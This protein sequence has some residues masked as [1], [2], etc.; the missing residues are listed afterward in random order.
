M[1]M[2]AT[3]VV[4]S[5]L[6]FV[7][8]LA[9]AGVLG[10][11]EFGRFAV[12]S[13]A[14]I[15][16]GTLAFDWLRLSTTRFVVADQGSRDPRLHP[17]L[18]AGYGAASLLLIAGGALAAS[19]AGTI[20]VDATTVAVVV[21]AAVANGAFEYRAALA[22]ALF[23]NRA[24][25]ALILSKNLLAFGLALGAG[26]VLGSAAA[27][28]AV[29]ALSAA[30]SA[31]GSRGLV[32][33]ARETT[34]GRPS[35]GHLALFARY[36]APIVGANLLYGA[37]VL[38]NR[39]VATSLFGYAAAGQISLPTD[40]TIRLFLSVGAALDVYLFQVVVRRRATDGLAGAQRQIAGNMVR[41]AAALVL[42]AVGYVMA[43][44]AFE[45]LVV[46][47]RF[48]GEFGRIATV[49]VPGVL[50]FCLVQFALSPVF[51]IENRTAPLLV[52]A[53]AAAALDVGL[54]AAM[55]GEPSLVALAWIHT[56]SLLGGSLV[57]LWP[58]LGKAA[59]WPP[60]REILVVLAAAGL[61][62]AALWPLRAIASPWLSLAASG[63]VG[64]AVFAAVLIGFD[65]ADLRERLL[66]VL[67][68]A[69]RG[70]VG[71]PPVAAEAKP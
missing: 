52:A 32:P 31:L 49:L 66:G 18:D 23:A 5:G 19:L 40:V 2:I 59:C 46:P 47:Q 56:A 58:A 34:S 55:P 50:T 33:A 12:A 65:V 3:F 61:T 26:L 64:P 62:A 9:L 13:M 14:A 54:L 38:L 71:T 22:R 36:G 16:L 11:E 15:V 51:Q 21:A 69:P 42:L 44:P 39:S 29:L 25:T 37:I 57:A 35:L 68:R 7:L 67:R 60:A 45:A 70:D 43:M 20:R 4:N 28:L 63:V 24:Y 27:V 8:G 1:W 17:S 48:Q 53:L 41:I 10:P 6:N 30:V